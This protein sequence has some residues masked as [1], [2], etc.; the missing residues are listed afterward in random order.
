MGEEMKISDDC[1][2]IIKQFEGFRASP[3]LCRAGKPTIGYGATFYPN[4]KPVTLKDAPISEP[5]ALDMLRSMASDFAKSVAAMLRRE[6]TQSQ[7]DAMVSFA[8]NV[9]L[10]TFK[11][12]TLLRKVNGGDTQGAANEF[13]KWVNVTVN[14]KKTRL[15]G[16]VNRRNAE[17]ALFLKA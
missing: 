7:F 3:Y 4:G 14:G 6:V 17:R 9:G 5:Q 16:L 8:Y 2:N 12:S 1:I 11:T 13:G 15:A 10:G